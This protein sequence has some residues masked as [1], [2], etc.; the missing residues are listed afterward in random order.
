[1]KSMYS[2]PRFDED[3]EEKKQ[4]KMPDPFSEKFLKTPLCLIEIQKFSQCFCW[5]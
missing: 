4:P 2:V 3:E 5:K 1:M